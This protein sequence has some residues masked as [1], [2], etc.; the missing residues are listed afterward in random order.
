VERLKVGGKELLFLQILSIDIIP[1][2]NNPILIIRHHFIK[3]QLSMTLPISIYVS[4]YKINE[5]S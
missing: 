4:K 1:S 5:Y 2:Q 3:V